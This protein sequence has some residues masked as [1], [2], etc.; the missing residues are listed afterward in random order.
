LSTNL[1]VLSDLMAIY[2]EAFC[3]DGYADFRVEMRILRRG[4]KEVIIHYG[5]QYRRVVDFEPDEIECYRV[6]SA[7]AMSLD[8]GQI[9]IL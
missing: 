4:Q 8:D 2:H 5:K 7:E 9:G 3:H 6:V 1:D